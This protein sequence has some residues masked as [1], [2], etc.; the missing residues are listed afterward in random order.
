WI[1]TLNEGVLHWAGGSLRRFGEAEGFADRRVLSLVDGPKGVYAG[2]PLGV[3]AFR[4]DSFERT[5]AEGFFAAA[6]RL[7][8]D[9]LLV[10][11]NDEGVVVVPLNQQRRPQ[12]P[13]PRTVAEGPRDVRAFAS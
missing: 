10:G 4:D 5:L 12:A 1:G 9:T 2:T 13:G 7:S 3:A 6:L 11:T 8:G